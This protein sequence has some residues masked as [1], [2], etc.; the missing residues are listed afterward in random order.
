MSTIAYKC[1][2][3]GGELSFDPDLQGYHCIYCD[4]NFTQ[5]ELMRRL[6]NQQE[7]HQET[8]SSTIARDYYCPNCGAE[9][10]TD[11]NT[12]ASFC[13]Y[14][15]APVIMRDRVEGR[16]APDY[17]LPFQISRK[18]AQDIF[19]NWIKKKRFVP[20]SFYSKDQIEKM[21]GVYFPFLLYNATVHADIDAVGT[22]RT[23][24][25]SGDYQEVTERLYQIT[26]SGDMSIENLSKIA[27]SKTN[28]ILVEGVQPFDFSKKEPFASSYL[29]GF[30]AEKKDM[31][32]ENLQDAV[33]QEVQNYARRKIDGNY[34][35]YSRIDYNQKDIRINQEEW[36]YALLPVWTI[37]YND[38]N[39]NKIYYFSINGQ[40]G[41]VIG[42]LP[43]DQKKLWFT[44]IMT[45]VLVFSIFCLIFYFLL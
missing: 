7:V 38:R 24:R 22:K 6:G 44:T 14:C 21:T 35:Q 36:K 4:S 34:A 27:L 43:I 29:S 10:V 26:D 5:E 23:T 25:R 15:Q 30:F 13:Y 17:V 2:N 39:K 40:N 20:R 18:K 3:C 8:F 28:K 31:E 42:D 11:E 19:S 32:R 37:T 41:R 9:I 12:V 16:F 1:P 45:G 33:Y